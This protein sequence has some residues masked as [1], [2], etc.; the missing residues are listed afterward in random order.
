MRI[1]NRK[2]YPP[3]IIYSA[4]KEVY[5]DRSCKES[6]MFTFEVTVPRLKGYTK[7][8]VYPDK[9]VGN[10]LRVLAESFEQDLKDGRKVIEEEV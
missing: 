9:E 2:K 4:K 7:F 3:Y 6:V 1:F 10:L 8:D 5:T